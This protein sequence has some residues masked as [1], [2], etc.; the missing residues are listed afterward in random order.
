MRLVGAM[1]SPVAVIDIGSNS[2]KALVAARNPDG[3]IAT[4]H[5]QSLDTRISTG[6]GDAKPQLTDEGIANGTAAVRALLD[7]VKPFGP[8]RIGLVATS[9]VRDA[10]NGDAFK[11]AIHEATGQELRIL[12]GNEEANL[13]GRGLLSDPA[14]SELRDFYVF[15]LGGGSLECLAFRDRQIEQAV[16]LP[17]GCVRLME[18]YI[19]DPAKPLSRTPRYRIMQHVHDDLVR[20]PFKFSL[21]LGTTAIGTGGTLA[22][23]RA[24]AGA[25]QN[26]TAEQTDSFIPLVQLRVLQ[27]R[28]SRMTLE[29]RQQVP[30]LPAARADVFPTALATL[31]VLCNV[32]ALEG[33]RHSFHNLRYGVAAELLG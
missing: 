30:G 15:D 6:I 27:T 11:A 21:P 1:P 23:V 14:L 2:I 33:F 9:A 10:A 4:V 7:A 18:Q 13:I 16:S 22:T 24:I 25:R 3:T 32:G 26:Q 20:A 28:V 31:I 19:K 12:S 5:A 29:E 17:L 8:E